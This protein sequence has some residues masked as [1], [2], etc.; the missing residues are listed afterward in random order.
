MTIVIPG[1]NPLGDQQPI[2]SS[3]EAVA[4]FRTVQDSGGVNVIDNTGL[5]GTQSFPT[6][7]GF[8]ETDFIT[9]STT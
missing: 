2:T 6:Y 9:T 1:E 8:I 5:V 3:V 7:S 4:R